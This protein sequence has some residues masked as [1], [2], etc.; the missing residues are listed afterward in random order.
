MASSLLFLAMTLSLSGYVRAENL[1]ALPI[2]CVKS[3]F[4]GDFCRTQGTAVPSSDAFHSFTV[5]KE[6]V[7]RQA[8]W[9]HPECVALSVEP[10]S[11]SQNFECH[12]SK[13]GPLDSDLQLTPKATYIFTYKSL[14]P[15]LFIGMHSDGMHYLVPNQ[16]KDW[17][18]CKDECAKV[19]GH[20]FGI[21]HSTEQYNTLVEIQQEI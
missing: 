17:E 1:T 7:C 15:T 18:D 14:S 9:A 12:L 5:N 21:F 11:K 16:R 13:K 20:R 6:C 4:Y 3:D 10:I 19:P 8:C 2:I